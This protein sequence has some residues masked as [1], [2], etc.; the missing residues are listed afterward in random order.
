MN[1]NN[2]EKEQNS[3]AGKNLEKNAARKKNWKRNYV[4][5]KKPLQVGDTSSAKKKNRCDLGDGR[6]GRLIS[7]SDHR[8][9]SR[10][11]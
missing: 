9:G 6:R 2:A 10:A 3:K 1:A 5:K 4:E 7:A 8:Q 11:N